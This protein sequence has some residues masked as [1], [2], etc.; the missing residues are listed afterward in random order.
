MFSLGVHGARIPD[1]AFVFN[2]KMALLPDDDS[3]IPFAPDVAVEVISASETAADSDAKVREYLEGGVS[4]VWQVYPVERRVRVRTAAG[5]R[6][7]GQE[8]TLVSPVLPGFA[9]TVS[10]FFRR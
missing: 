8:A 1:V 4:E 2:N 6:E 5:S 10:E 3:P 7:F 9:V